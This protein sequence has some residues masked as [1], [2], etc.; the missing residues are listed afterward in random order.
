MDLVIG[1]SDRDVH[2]GA[3]IK[4]NLVSVGLT[5][6]QIDKITCDLKNDIIDVLNNFEYVN[7]PS[8]EEE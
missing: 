8:H 1:K 4:S 6:E 7:N 2:L 5:A 3:V